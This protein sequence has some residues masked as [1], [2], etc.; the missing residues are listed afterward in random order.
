MEILKNNEFV[1]F[2]WKN[3]EILRGP[4]FHNSPVRQILIWRNWV[5]AR[6][7]FNLLII[8]KELIKGVFLHIQ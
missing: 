4:Y 7:W 6:K 1:N 8:V 3:A 2:I 5:V